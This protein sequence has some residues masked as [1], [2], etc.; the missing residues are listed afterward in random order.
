MFTCL[1]EL[2]LISGLAPFFHKQDF[3]GWV[4]VCVGSGKYNGTNL[5]SL[6]IWLQIAVSEGGNAGKTLICS[7]Q[8]RIWNRSATGATCSAN[9]PFLFRFSFKN[10]FFPHQRLILETPI[11]TRCPASVLSLISTESLASLDQLGFGMLGKQES[12]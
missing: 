9:T 10:L 5:H 11:A 1:S 2:F 6:R 4:F 8:V 7:R 3:F 12:L